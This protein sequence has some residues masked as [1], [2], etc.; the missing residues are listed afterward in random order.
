MQL[1]VSEVF[2]G[3]EYKSKLACG[4][5]KTVRNDK[6]RE[7]DEEISRIEKSIKKIKE[8]TQQE[9]VENFANKILKITF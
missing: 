7:M 5:F 9:F 4:H 2:R 6:R 3:S 1:T 8:L